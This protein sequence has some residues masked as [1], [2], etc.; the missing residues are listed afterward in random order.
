M[1]WVYIIKSEKTDRYYTGSCGNIEIR[2]REHNNNQTKTTKHRGPYKLIYKEK[3]ELKKDAL[4]RE[5][6][7]KNYK[8]GRAF[9]KL[10]ASPSS[11]LA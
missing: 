10:V 11:S 6:Q 1:F 9:K 8:S 5:K 7:I 2:L 4:S 3:F